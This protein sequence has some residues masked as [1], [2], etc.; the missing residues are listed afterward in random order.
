MILILESSN[1]WTLYVTSPSLKPTKRT[2]LTPQEPGKQ[3][4]EHKNKRYM[5]IL[6]CLNIYIAGCMIHHTKM[7]K[8]STYNGSKHTYNSSIQ[9]VHYNSFDINIIAKMKWPTTLIFW[10][11]V[12]PA[13]S[14]VAATFHPTIGQ[15]AHQSLSNTATP[16]LGMIPPRI[17]VNAGLHISEGHNQQT[18][19]TGFTR[20]S[21][22]R[23]SQH[24]PRDNHCISAAKQPFT[25]LWRGKDD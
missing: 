13:T 5:L 15:H 22:D 4:H 1:K 6:N 21:T 3:P 18:N 14:Y 11:R 12:Y 17:R 19:T 20:P 25:T 16:E 24:S 7:H 2:R 23:P 9:H 8:T 10:W